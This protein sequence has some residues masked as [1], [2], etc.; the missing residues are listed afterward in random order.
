MYIIVYSY[1]LKQEN[2]CL[3]VL[4]KFLRR[5]ISFERKRYSYH[6]ARIIIKAV[7]IVIKT[8][9]LI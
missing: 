1:K 7:F 2:C 5:A 3:R 6:I 4:V 9:P 8:M